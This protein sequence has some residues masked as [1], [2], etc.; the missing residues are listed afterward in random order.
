M[1]CKTCN[2]TGNIK[3]A[4][5]MRVS[6]LCP[7]CEGNG[8]IRAAPS[9]SD[10]KPISRGLCEEEAMSDELW[11]DPVVR[12]CDDAG[13]EYARGT[14]KELAIQVKALKA[15]IATYRAAYELAYGAACTYG[16]VCEQESGTTRR[17]D[18]DMMAAD[19]LVRE[20]RQRN[21][22]AK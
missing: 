22:V 8:F 16:N 6:H 10:A 4:D 18:R 2:G 3:S 11:A 14:P 19:D 13:V 9:E 7:E 12:Y 17:A 5:R 20:M 1:L 15:D 21:E